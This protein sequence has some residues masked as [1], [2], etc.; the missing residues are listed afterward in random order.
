MK[1]ILSDPFGVRKVKSRLVEV[2][3]A[4]KLKMRLGSM[5]ANRKKSFN[6]LH[7]H[8]FESIE[9]VETKTKKELKAVVSSL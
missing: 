1:T 6:P 8:R 2:C 7:G 9:V 4:A 3:E 5:H